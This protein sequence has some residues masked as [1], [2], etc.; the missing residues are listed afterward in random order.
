ME[1]E[2]GT[3]EVFFGCNCQSC[4]P[5][6]ITCRIEQGSA[7]VS[8]STC[9]C[10][11]SKMTASFCRVRKLFDAEMCLS[12]AARAL[13]VPPPRHLSTAAALPNALHPR[14]TYY[15]VRAAEASISTS[16]ASPGMRLLC[17]LLASASVAPHA[18]LA[19]PAAASA[20]TYVRR[21]AWNVTPTKS[22]LSVSLTSPHRSWFERL[23]EAPTVLAALPEP[24]GPAL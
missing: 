1:A 2:I 8:C 4:I 24:A 23:I 6:H 9:R 12:A 11:P 14:T 7:P 16:S 18:F 17:N 22:S 13:T 20:T 10:L 15:P 5:R 19:A 21:C 3:I